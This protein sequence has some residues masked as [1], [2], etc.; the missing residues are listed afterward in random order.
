MITV[1]AA[2]E[3][4]AARLITE[5]ATD[6]EI[7]GLQKLFATVEDNTSRVDIDGYSDLNIRFHQAI[8]ALSKSQLLVTM[9]ETLFIHNVLYS[10]ADHR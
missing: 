10:G 8:I 7:A 2:L 6:E 9:T 4:M 1:W 5:N 3:S